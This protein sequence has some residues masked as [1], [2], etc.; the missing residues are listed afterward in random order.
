M[1]LPSLL[2]PSVLALVTVVAARVGET[3]WRQF[4]GPTGQGLSAAAGVP[5]EWDTAKNVAW[6]TE[7][8]GRGWSSP[9]IAGGRVYLTS[10]TGSDAGAEPALRALCI[11]AASGALVWDTEVFRPDP[12]ALGAIHQKNS[13]ASPTPIVAGERLYVHFGHMGTAALD[14]TGKVL[15]RQ[16]EIQYPPVHGGGGSPVLAEDA[17]VF[18]ADGAQD[19]FIVALEAATGVVRWKTP[20]RTPAR[21]Q[22]SFS[23]PLGIEV[24]GAMQIISPASGMVG[25]YDPRDGREL[26]R[27]TYGEGYSVVPCPAYAHGLLYVSSGFD[28]PVLHAIR[29]EQATGDATAN[30]VAWTLAKGAPLTPSPLVL[31]DELYLVSDAGIATCADAHTGQVHWTERLGGGFSASPFAAEGR[32]YFQNEAGVGFVVRAG[33]T[34]ELLTRNDLAERTLASPAAVDGAIFIRSEKHLWKIGS[35]AT[36]K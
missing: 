18:S 26:W 35:P 33:K 22:F 34:F 27:V 14:L 19:P 30:H 12:A 32:V 9:V 24:A 8:P 17:L 29:P 36:L 5:I 31:G 2:L 15:W 6:K 3:E 20:R 25:G 4:R 10:A 13:P 21:R 16:T 23:T 1:N 7:V 11:D 28:R